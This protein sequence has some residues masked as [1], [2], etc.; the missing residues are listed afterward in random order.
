M[1]QFISLF[2]F[3]MRVRFSNSEPSGHEKNE[4]FD[5]SGHEK[6]KCRPKQFKEQVKPAISKF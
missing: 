3:E 2:R 5:S 1:N 4:N 6:I